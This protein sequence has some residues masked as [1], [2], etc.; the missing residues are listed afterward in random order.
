MKLEDDFNMMKQR[1]DN[2]DL[3]IFRLNE[4]IKHLQSH[5]S[6]V[7]ERNIL[8]QS[9]VDYYKLK[10][11]SP[12]CNDDGSDL[13]IGIEV[14]PAME[15]KKMQTL[16]LIANYIREIESLKSALSQANKSQLNSISQ[17]S[18]NLNKMD[19]D[20]S[21]LSDDD[22]NAS[23]MNVMSTSALEGELTANVAK[24]ISETQLELYNEQKRLLRLKTQSAAKKNGSVLASSDEMYCSDDG[25][26]ALDSSKTS[27][28]FSLVQEEDRTYQRRQKIMAAEMTDIS[29]S[30]QVKEQ[31]VMQLQKSQ[32][33][34]ELMKRFYEE[35]LLTLCRE[36]DVKEAEKQRMTEELQK[37]FVLNK[38]ASQKENDKQRGLEAEMSLKEKLS[39]KENELKALR[40]KQEELSSLSKV[41]SRSSQQISKLEA[42]IIAMKRQRVELSLTLQQEKR[43]HYIALNQKVKEIDKLKREL[44]KTTAKMQQLGVEKDNAQQKVRDIIRE[45]SAKRR[46]GSVNEMSKNL[47]T[48]SR[49]SSGESAATTLRRSLRV[50]TSE[51]KPLTENQEK[52]KKWLDKQVRDIAAREE[53]VEK[54][55]RQYE[56]QLSLHH[57]KKMLEES[58][59][60]I[61]DV[62][63]SAKLDNNPTLSGG[64]SSDEVLSI[65]E[66]EALAEIE[67]RIS[68]LDGQL[69]YRNEQISSI[70][71]SLDDPNANSGRISSTMQKLQ[72]AAANSLPAA[73]ELIQII[74]NMLVSSKKTAWS[75]KEILA[76]YEEREKKL[77]NELEELKHRLSSMTRQHAKDI[78]RLDREYD[79]KISGLVEY[80]SFG[81]L[82]HGSQQ[83]ETT[84]GS[85]S[86]PPES[87]RSTLQSAFRRPS[88][89][90]SN[91]FTEG[92][93]DSNDGE[94]VD[95]VSAL[96]TMLMVAN[97]KNT[98]YKERLQREENRIMIMNIT[99][100]E[101]KAEQYELNDKLLSKD[102]DI[103][104]LEDEC[105]ML[106]EM[107][108]DLKIKLMKGSPANAN[109]TQSL[110]SAVDAGNNN[111]EMKM[112]QRKMSAKSNISSDDNVEDGAD[113]D[114][115]LS[116]LFS[117]LGQEI[118]QHGELRYASEQ[119][120]S[121]SSKKS[122]GS[123]NGSMSNA[124]KNIFDRL[125]N[126]NNFT[127]TQKNI[128]EQDIE[129][130]RAKVAHV[131]EMELQQK[132]KKEENF[133][134]SFT[135]SF[136]SN[137]VTSGTSGT[138]GSSGTSKAVT[139]NS[140]IATT[141]D[142]A[143]N[144]INSEGSAH[145]ADAAYNYDDGNATAATETSY[146]S[147][148]GK[149]ADTG[150]VA[151]PTSIMK[152]VNSF[153]AGSGKHVINPND[154]AAAS[155][156]GG[157]NVFSRLLNPEKFTGIHKRRQ[158]VRNVDNDSIDDSGRGLVTSSAHGMTPSHVSL[159]QSLDS[160]HSKASVSSKGN[161]GRD[162]NSIG[163]S[164][165]S[166]RYRSPPTQTVQKNR[167]N[168][169]ITIP[170][171]SPSSSSSSSLFPSNEND[172]S[173]VFTQF[174]QRIVGG[175][176]NGVTS[177]GG[178][179][180]TK[181]GQSTRGWAST[182]GNY[183]S[184]N[185]SSVE[186][187]KKMMNKTSPN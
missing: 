177:G 125:T 158:N 88:N 91:I 122:Y 98:T 144:A 50:N 57:K 80:S 60:S 186:K 14:D 129:I 42:D 71:L 154:I 110:I 150:S 159:L 62:I 77:L 25:G 121:S 81:Q 101:L 66:E 45:N 146:A 145:F 153:S 94:N 97:D 18:L 87:V 166:S 162:F 108:S 76:R 33:Q 182:T 55:K 75:R 116:I 119:K 49:D 2:G 59:A 24:V 10:Y 74:F 139:A 73:H 16:P 143:N 48:N 21:F 23:S 78:D 104:F 26:D 35:K 1:S 123:Y 133:F 152:N 174:R 128:F 72:T 155:S 99:I 13:S 124:D 181:K 170:D 105:R 69:K 41:H 142:S 134:L 118:S 173:N 132:K 89:S 19:E 185:S 184:S 54:L 28:Q 187:D 53:A 17:Y 30:I 15:E 137:N 156:G 178:G 140:A 36:M 27:N 135:N 138:T 163:L 183:F 103:K 40:Q 65:E 39:D 179:T 12:S 20:F 82:L 52:M 11:E 34:Y 100:D 117:S 56:L 92:S 84:A 172:K 8:L 6:D 51:R 38:S 70:E 161:H 3:E 120:T 167:S 96:R 115:N 109:N 165:N 151:S 114:E 83:A 111:D 175:G 127:G 46:L 64:G 102:R 131:K 43:N 106:Q 68:T 148:S 85:P 86:S 113:T 4:K 58:R 147:R 126:P 32:K 136:I 107:V 180:D 93:V 31:L 160:S 141:G 130:N 164:S 63:V 67:D 9:E 79:E 44:L 171:S 47:P 168:G 149:L 37:L 22:N 95:V 157:T 5:V 29:E 176:N 61:R 112:R 90:Y 169:S 7:N